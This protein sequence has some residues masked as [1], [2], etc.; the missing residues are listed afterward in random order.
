MLDI[1]KNQNIKIMNKEKEL[2]VIAFVSENNDCDE[3]ICI[4][5]LNDDIILLDYNTKDRFFPRG[6]ISKAIKA[7]NNKELIKKLLLNEMLTNLI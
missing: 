1:K 3:A 4:K 6:N 7:I 2:K 5:D